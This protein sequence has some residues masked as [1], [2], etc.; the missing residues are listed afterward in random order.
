LKTRLVPL[1]A[2]LFLAGCAAGPS[3]FAEMDLDRNGRIS[4]GE[5]TDSIAQI[6]F[7][8][9]DRNH[10]GYIDLAEWRAGESGGNEALFRAR[11]LSRNGRISPQ[12][13]RLAAEKNGSM[14]ALFSTVDSNHDGLIDADEA[15]RYRATL[16]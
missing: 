14:N 3:N 13:A 1:F 8:S 5:F 4:R 7:A 12:E 11:D 15:R 10:D 16:R 6:S 2:L 9:L